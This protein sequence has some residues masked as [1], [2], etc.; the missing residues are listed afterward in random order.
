MKRQTPKSVMIDID[1][2]NVHECSIYS[3]AIDGEFEWIELIEL[4][5]PFSPRAPAHALMAMHEYHEYSVHPRN[6]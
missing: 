1:R 5:E 3:A 4:I 2:A 6:T